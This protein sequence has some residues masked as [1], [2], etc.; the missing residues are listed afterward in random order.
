[1]RSLDWSATPVGPPSAWPASLKSAVAI[2]LRSRH[3]MFLWWGPELVQFYNDAYLPSFGTGKHPAAMGQ[4][5]ADCW[6]EIWP[7]IWPQID[8]VMARGKASWN[9]DHLVPIFRNGRIEEV[10]WTYGYSPVL[11]DQGSVH[12]T[13]VVC[14]ETTGRVISERRLKIQQ[15]LQERAILAT[16]RERLLQEAAATFGEAP[17]DIPFA[18][19]YTSAPSTRVL[20]LAASVGVDGAALATVDRGVRARSEAG[21]LAGREPIAAL[22]IAGGGVACGPWPEPTADAF[23]ST[24]AAAASGA[25]GFVVFGL[26]PRLAFDGAYEDWLSQLTQSLAVSLERLEAMRVRALVES[27]RRSVLMQAP[28]ATALLV[29]PEHRYELTNP[30]Y[31]EMMQREGLVGKTYVEAF[32]ELLGTESVALLDRT[33]RTGEGFAAEE[34][35][36]LLAKSDGTIS[37]RFFKFNLEPIRDADD[38][39]YGMMVIAVDVTE[40]VAARRAL[41]RANTDRE[42][43]LIDAQ[44]ARQAAEQ[45]NQLK[46]QFLAAVSHELRTP[47]NAMLGWARMLIAGQLPQE[48]RAKALSTIER[49]AV[50][51]ARL[52]DDLL[53]VG[54]IVSGKMRVE[55][56]PFDLTGSVEAAL[57]AVRPA[58]EAKGVRLV[59]RVAPGGVVLDG[60]PERL[61]QVA[62]N[63]LSNAIKF[64]PKGGEVSLGL[65][66]VDGQ[67]ELVVADSGRGIAPAFLAHVFDPFRQYDGGSSR[68]AGGL[69]LGLTIAKTIVDLHG[70]TLRARSDGMGK[71]ATFVVRLPLVR[72]SR[73]SLHLASA[74][75]ATPPPSSEG[76]AEARGIRVLVVEDDDD[77]RELLFAALGERGLLVTAAATAQE[78]I[79]ACTIACPDVVVSDVAM[80]GEDGYAFLR[81]L[82]ALPDETCRRVP[83]VA[84]TAFARG[85]D[86]ERA[87]RAGFALHLPKPV[88][89]N[90]LIAA[91]ASLVR[92]K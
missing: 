4:R 6:A 77:S 74:S 3:P 87:L 79:D 35:P 5:G 55:T 49:S 63:L 23:V 52:I 25:R 91:L 36:A 21:V 39:V 76:L 37:E 51:Q 10:Y 59:S 46:D 30:R 45:A 70:G 86:G 2:L 89:T 48:A 47:L 16:T 26:S 22:G 84:L 75:A 61:E 82:R 73:A 34:Y 33:Y 67:A 42:K 85:E 20:S 7:I 72:P 15:A 31:C 58:A 50:V 41:E 17:H 14:T 71:G 19:L 65:D 78:G 88:H 83:V 12:G 40:Q 56:Q 44:G 90:E 9:E 8:D 43:L 18:L 66:V 68:A 57:E 69:G 24:F 60:D 27:E 62:W 1:M 81:R 54:R 92:P 29:G 32:P 13:L 80:P 64:T 28:V 53:D 11:D 38:Q